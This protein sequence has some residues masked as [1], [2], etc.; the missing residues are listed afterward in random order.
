MKI[1]VCQIPLVRKPECIY[2]HLFDFTK[3]KIALSYPFKSELFDFQ[4]PSWKEATFRKYRILPDSYAT[5]FPSDS[6]IRAEAEIISGVNFTINP[7]TAHHLASYYH[8]KLRTYFGRE[9]FYPDRK[10]II[11]LSRADVKRWKMASEFLV[12]ISGIA[13][14]D[15]FKDIQRLP[16]NYLA[17][18]VPEWAGSSYYALHPDSHYRIMITLATAS[19]AYG[20]LHLSSWNSYFSTVVE[21]WLWMSSSIFVVFFGCIPVT[22]LFSS[23]LSSIITKQLP[24]FTREL[25]ENER[26]IILRHSLIVI[27]LGIGCLLY[28]FVRG[29]I[30]VEAFIA[31]R[32]LP[33]DYYDTPV[34]SNLIPH[35]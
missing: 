25:R 17:A 30:V 8:E 6:L 5:N 16:P 10:L 11:T 23:Y 33:L 31:L 32:Q 9:R 3:K 1:P 2:L 26:I 21:R 20:G 28:C 14:K 18:K 29:F 35:L 7:S 19:A 15:L 13:D 22:Y 12:S 34:W 4:D 24:R 27:L